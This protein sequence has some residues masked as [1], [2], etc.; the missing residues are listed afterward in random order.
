MSFRQLLVAA[1]RVAMPDPTEE[2]ERKK[3]TKKRAQSL[4]IIGGLR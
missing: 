2:E 4:K 1:T 3:K